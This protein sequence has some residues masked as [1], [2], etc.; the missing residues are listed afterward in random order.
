[1]LGG[2]VIVRRPW[3]VPAIAARMMEVLADYLP[4]VGSGSLRL[5]RLGDDAGPIGALLLARGAI[6]R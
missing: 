5:A 6:A 3:L 2:G 1:M 4:D